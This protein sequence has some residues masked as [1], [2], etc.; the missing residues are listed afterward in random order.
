[1]PVTPQDVLRRVFGYGGFR[2][3]QEAIIA[4]TID[5][6]D[7]L[8]LMPTGAGKSLCYQIPALV[9]TGTALV[10]SPLIALMRDQVTTLLQAGGARGVPQLDTR[11]PRGARRRGGAAYRTHRPALRGSRAA[12][13]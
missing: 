5:G 12:A 1:M 4:H 6:G 7:S 3:Q 10:V 11:L 2:G 9:R 13:G 8:V